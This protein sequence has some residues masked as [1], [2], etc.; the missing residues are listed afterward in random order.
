MRRPPLAS[1]AW[2][3]SHFSYVRLSATLWIVAPQALLSMGFLQ[4]RILEWIA[5]SI[6][7]GSTVG[8]ILRCRGILYLMGHEGLGERRLHLA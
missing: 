2:V 7:V 3:L 8:S 5:V 1:L 4:A 6:S